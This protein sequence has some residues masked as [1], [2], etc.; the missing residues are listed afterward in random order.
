MLRVCVCIIALVVRHEDR[1]CSAPLLY[2]HLWPVWPPCFST[3]SHKRHDIFFA[4]VWTFL[5]IR[6]IHWYI[7]IYIYI[8]IYMHLYVHIYIHTCIYI[9]CIYLYI[10]IYIHSYIYIYIH[11]HTHTHTSIHKRMSSCKAPVILARFSFYILFSQWQVRW[12]FIIGLCD[13]YK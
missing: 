13:Q 1:I 7:Y 2:C 9:N 3:S 6:R 11:T 4:F 5:I 10:H 12:L 8:Y